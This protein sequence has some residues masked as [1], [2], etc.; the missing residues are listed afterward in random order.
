ME[1]RAITQ[2]AN[3][4]LP[5]AGF[6]PELLLA[7]EQA[8]IAFFARVR[9][10]PPAVERVAIDDAV[11]RVI[12]S[13]VGADADYPAVPRSA[14]DGFA[15]AAAGTPGAFTICN[16]VHMGE[17]PQWHVERG[18]AARIPTGGTLPR[19]TDAV[20]PIEDARV[21]GA[22]VHVRDAFDAGTNVVECGADMRRGETI[23]TPGTHVR[24]PQAGLL[25][26]LGVTQVAVYRRPVIGVFSSGDELVDTAETPAPGQIRDSN[27]YATA[28]SLCAMGAQPRH[29]P[30][31]RDERDDFVRAL[32]NALKECDAVTVSGGSSV[33]ARD[34]L[35]DA[36][37]A[38]G[39]PGIVVHGLR[40]KP[41]KP[42]LLGAVGNKPIL[43][44]PG[45][46]TSALLVLE[47]VAAPIVTALTGARPAFACT[48]SARLASPL[49]SRA[50]WTWY[51]PVALRN[52]GG[53]LLAHPLPLRSFSVS[54][55]AR[56]DG[57]VVM[58][59]GDEEWPADTPVAVHQFLGSLGVR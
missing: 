54:L 6:V 8:L 11:G 18:L 15:L 28:A 53:A 25:A 41:G 37:A 1:K 45:N 33:G 27:R 48:A 40:I 31:L 42:T 56:A 32:S 35:P 47:A 5:G 24:A 2:P 29:Y 58:G 52:E 17:S 38:L 10:E 49:R 30:R 19:G 14:M 9:I 50:G 34:A 22:I 59:E 26:T 13:S 39:E 55:A 51:V 44:L 57:Y 4:L 16:D 43:G 21:E 46:P 20:V 23:L 3:A 12:A 7:P 36:V